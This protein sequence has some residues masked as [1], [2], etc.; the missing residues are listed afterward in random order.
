M[1]IDAAIGDN[2]SNDLI[3]RNRRTTLRQTNDAL[4]KPLYVYS[5]LLVA[6]QPSRIETHAYRKLFTKRAVAKRPR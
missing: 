3:A 2:K 5:C 6:D 1:N 4:V